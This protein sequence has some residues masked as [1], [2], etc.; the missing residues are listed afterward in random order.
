M[1]N[2]VFPLSYKWLF[3]F[4]HSLLQWRRLS[5][6]VFFQYHS[7]VALECG[8]D[9]YLVVD[10]DVE[11]ERVESPQTKKKEGLKPVQSTKIK[12]KFWEI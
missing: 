9:I 11:I 2:K 10:N 5:N 6:S 1:S 12:C 4:S 3:E 8:L 7:E